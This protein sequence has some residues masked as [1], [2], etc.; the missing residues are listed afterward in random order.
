MDVARDRLQAFRDAFNAHAREALRGQVLQPL[1]RPDLELPLDQVDLDFIHWLGY[2]GP[3]GIGNP[4]PLFIAQG[5]E[6]DGPR[7][8]GDTHLKVSLRGPGTKL[9][10]IGFGLAERH[11]P[12]SLAPG[13]YDVLVKLERNEW[14]GVASPQAQIVD[15]RPS[16][17][18]AT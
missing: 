1:L 5:V 7:R 16:V 10:G 15:L 12:E 17:E 6:L 18:A 3:H 2:L 9:D 13:R 11:P 14:R 4:R 8:V